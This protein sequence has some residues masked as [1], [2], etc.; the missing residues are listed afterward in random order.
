MILT[1]REIKL[2]LSKHQIGIDPP[3]PEQAYSSTA[4]DLTLHKIARRFKTDAT[5]GLRLDPAHPDYSYH[6]VA[7]VLTEEVNTDPEFN[8]EGRTLL[9][10]WTEE[11]V[12]LP[13]SSRVA[14]RVEGKS[15]LS[16]LGLAV[17]ITAPTIHA[18]FGGQ[19]QLEIINHG[20]APVT[21]RAGMRICQLIFE[22]TLGTPEKGYA[23][24]F[25]GQTAD[26]ASP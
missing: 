21:L 10:A 16:R 26:D 24:I 20:P 18:G 7:S 13:E 2:A 14:A 6:A 5:G 8:L 12:A 15:S 4:V 19:I 9:L 1:D 22:T 17:H 25:A 3:P 11:Y 23:G